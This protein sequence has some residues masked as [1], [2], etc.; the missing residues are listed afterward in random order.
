[1]LILKQ[2]PKIQV[3]SED[4]AHS[5]TCTSCMLD[6]LL[7]LVLSWFDRGGRQKVQVVCR[8]SP[9]CKQVKAQGVFHQS[10]ITK[11][12]PLCSTSSHVKW[13]L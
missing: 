11:A 7:A 4:T 1:M 10:S 8:S 6:G 9:C 5:I 12:S 2:L 13:M 3:I